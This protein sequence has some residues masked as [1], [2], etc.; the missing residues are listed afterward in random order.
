MIA[1]IVAAFLAGV[2]AALGGLFFYELRDGAR[3]ALARAPRPWRTVTNAQ[4]STE[5]TFR[6]REA[7]LG[8]LCGDLLRLASTDRSLTTGPTM[9]QRIE[10]QRYRVF[11]SWRMVFTV[12]PAEQEPRA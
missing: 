2:F 6:T 11:V 7:T 10:P 9:E 1:S 8:G 4:G 5:I 12:D 3:R